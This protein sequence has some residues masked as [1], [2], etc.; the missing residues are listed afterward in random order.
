[1]CT[2]PDFKQRF[3]QLEL[4][5]CEAVVYPGSMAFDTEV[6]ERLKHKKALKILIE[7]GHE[8]SK[9]CPADVFIAI[10][11]CL[12]RSEHLGCL[13]SFHDR[14]LCAKDLL[15]YII[16]EYFAYSPLPFFE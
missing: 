11:P 13:K 4:L 3:A 15:R 2:T 8:Q 1:M 10:H 6:G 12:R 16:V 5:K 14:R 9:V 7:V